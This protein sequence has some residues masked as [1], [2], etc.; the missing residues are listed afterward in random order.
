MKLF[1]STSRRSGTETVI[2][3]AVSGQACQSV[4]SLM[5]AIEYL[6]GVGHSA[7]LVIDDQKFYIDGDGHCS[8]IYIKVNGKKN[9]KE[10][11]L[12]RLKKA[13]IEIACVG[14]AVGIV[15]KILHL[16]HQMGSAGATRSMVIADWKE[17]E[18]FEAEFDGDGS[19]KVNSIGIKFP[20][21]L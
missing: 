10:K 19:A 21:S 20:T 4:P 2:T 8:I 9:W 3:T 7:E 17:G 5:K 12:S 11:D 1:I 14:D 18:K 16:L 6:G 13:E 15:Q